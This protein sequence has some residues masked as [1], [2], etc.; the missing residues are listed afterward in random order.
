M[1]CNNNTN[2][3]RIDQQII[4]QQIIDQQIINER[5]Q[6]IINPNYL[7]DSILKKYDDTIISKKYREVWL[8]EAASKWVDRHPE[9]QKTLMNTLIKTIEKIENDEIDS[10]NIYIVKYVQKGGEIV[11]IYRLN[12]E[13]IYKGEVLEELVRRFKNNPK[14][15]GAEEKILDAIKN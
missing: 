10:T 1:S 15:E 14:F 13:N 2:K 4:D 3:K 5:A 6:N 8:R 11:D 7:T 12:L 9:P